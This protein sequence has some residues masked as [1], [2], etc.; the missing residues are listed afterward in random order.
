MHLLID[1]VYQS[2]K[3]FLTYVLKRKQCLLMHLVDESCVVEARG[4]INCQFGMK[5]KVEPDYQFIQF[6][7]SNNAW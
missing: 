3:S 5:K 1:W 6:L 4:K 7:S 2:K